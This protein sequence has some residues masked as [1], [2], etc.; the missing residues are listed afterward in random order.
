MCSWGVYGLHGDAEKVPCGTQ[1]RQGMSLL[2]CEYVKCTNSGCFNL[3]A[4]WK[5][6]ASEILG[7][8]Y[9]CFWL[10]INMNGHI[11]IC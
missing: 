4:N 7:R 6:R 11:Q 2:N 9:A 1:A 3:I 5:K 8:L 10:S